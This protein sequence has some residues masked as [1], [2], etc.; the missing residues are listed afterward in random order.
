[1]LE[2]RSLT[3]KLRGF[4]L[5]PLDMTVK[6][7]ELALV[8]GPNGAGKSTLL[9]TIAGLY[10]PASGSIVLD[11]RDITRAPIESRSV[12]YVPQSYALFEHMSVRANIEFGLRIRRVPAQE[13]EKIVLELARKLDIIDLLD[14]KPRELSGGQMQRVAIARALAVRPR[15]L[16]LDE[17]LSNLDPD[18]SERSLDIIAEATKEFG[19]ST[20]VVSQSVTRPL[21]VADSVYFMKSGRIIDL[22]RPEEA[23]SNPRVLEAAMYMGFDN[24]F[25]ASRF[26]ETLRLP[27]RFNLVDDKGEFVAFRPSSAV[28]APAGGCRGPHLQG[29]VISIYYVT[30]GRGRALIDVGLGKPVRCSIGDYRPAP[31]EVVDVCIDLAG[32]STVSRWP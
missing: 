30:E 11:G 18:S 26:F 21:R 2:I 8:F 9:K 29:R 13:R 4:T 22:G 32:V 28:V 3:V 15:A 16:L 19:L 5:G 10:V 24:I 7:G 27:E 6:D 25:E 14:R 31:G 20:I 23:V 1:M 12:G 17:P